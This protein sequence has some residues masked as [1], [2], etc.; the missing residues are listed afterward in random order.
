MPVSMLKPQLWEISAK[1]FVQLWEGLTP[2][3]P[4]LNLQISD[5]DLVICYATQGEAQGRVARAGMGLCTIAGL[6]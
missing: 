2:T 5:S 6:V 1:G 3:K 4:K